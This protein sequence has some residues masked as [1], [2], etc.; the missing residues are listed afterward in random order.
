MTA[1]IPPVPGW[2]RRDWPDL[3][4]FLSLVADAARNGTT[5]AELNS[6]IGRLPLGGVTETTQVADTRI[7]RGPFMA[8]PP[9]PTGFRVRPGVGL[10][11]VS[12]TNPWSLY[13]NHDLTRVYRGTTN[14]FADAMEIGVSR[15]VIYTDRLVTTGD[16][17]YYWVQWQ[18]KS[19]TT[20]PLAGPLEITVTADIS[21]ALDAIETE[22][23]N[24]PLTEDLLSP[25]DTTYLDPI[26]Q[27]YRDTVEALLLYSAMVAQD[28]SLQAQITI[29]QDALNTSGTPDVAQALMAL[30]ARVTNAEGTIMANATAVTNL[31]ISVAGKAST[32]AVSMLDTR[33]TANESGITANTTLI[34]NLTTVVDGKADAS[35]VT[36]LDTRITTNQNNIT[37]NSTQLTLLTVTV[38]GKAD[39]SALQSLD[40]RVVVTETGTT[41]NATAITNLMVSLTDGL[42]EKADA[43]ALQSLDARVVVTETGTTAN[44]TA[45]TNLMVSLTNGLAE[46]AEAVA[47]Q[48]LDARVTTAE[49]GI[50]A[51]STAVTALEVTVDDKADV[52]IVETLEARVVINEDGLPDLKAQWTVKTD[53][54]GLVGSVGLLND[55]N[56]T[57]FYVAADRFAIIDPSNLGE[58]P[59]VPF[60]VQDGTVFMRQALVGVLEADH[61]SADVQNATVLWTSGNNNGLMLNSAP[62]LGT[63]LPVL[64]D[65]NRFDQLSF[66]IRFQ[67]D[68][69][70]TFDTGATIYTAIPNHPAF[71]RVHFGAYTESGPDFNNVML[72][73]RVGFTSVRVSQFSARP[74][75][76]FSLIQVMG[77]QNPAQN[78]APSSSQTGTGVPANPEPPTYG[79]VERTS[80]RA[81]WIL[82]FNNGSP[83]TSASLQFREV[84]AGIFT[85]NIAAG[86]TSWVFDNLYGGVA[87]ASRIRIFNANGGSGWS[88]W[89][90]VVTPGGP[91]ATDFTLYYDD[92]RP[93]APN[94]AGGYA[95]DRWDI[96]A[97]DNPSW[98]QIRDVAN[99]PYDPTPGGLADNPGETTAVSFS[100]V[101]ADGVNQM[102]RHVEIGPG[103]IFVYWVRNGQ[104]SAWNVLAGEISLNDL[105]CTVELGARIAFDES[106]STAAPGD[107]RVELR[108]TQAGQE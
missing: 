81:N 86:V 5:G 103:S 72:L 2:V 40:A 95:F 70:L 108:F 65:V 53:V 101:D 49:E 18:A 83:L 99:P 7:G 75:A 61:I 51:T 32:S 29:V 106:E 97:Y 31:Q 58:D 87:Y 54:N 63:V 96:T 27:L 43:S 20:G 89:S 8:T 56:T 26:V 17:Y 6:A 77:F 24:D 19:G 4:N 84:G 9:V 37:A 78:T 15:S 100:L 88:D 68:D 79:N 59:T 67:N 91:P 69:G 102:A 90:E 60:F 1:A 62:V 36:S 39:S 13:R 82:P 55:G 104:W 34:T 85:H 35:A 14:V 42:A 33:V 10:V 94:M 48:L 93:P 74:G 46:K 98:A 41:A 28:L 23:L 76:S 47:L 107:R 71:K 57:R 44:A 21:T 50:T 16:L 30:D 105:R 11:A 52:A 73:S 22:I 25:T 66:T 92:I 12:W 64:A 3:G 80:L 38:D 45:I